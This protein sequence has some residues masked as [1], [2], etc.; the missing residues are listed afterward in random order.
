M[1]VLPLLLLVVLGMVGLA[2]LIISEQ[3]LAEAGGRAARA[4]ALGK[5]DE[6]IA[7]AARSVLGDERAANAT[8]SVRPVGGR[9]NEPVPPGGLV[10]VRIEIAARHATTTRLALVDPDEVLIGRAVMQRE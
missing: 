10:E 9:E 7:A 8:I 4:A 2:D 3:M 6:E 5:S 1:L